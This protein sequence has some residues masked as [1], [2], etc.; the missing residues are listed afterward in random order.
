M[1]KSNVCPYSTIGT[2]KGFLLQAWNVCLQKCFDEEITFLIDIFTNNGQLRVKEKKNARK[3][4]QKS[5]HE[6]HLKQ[7]IKSRNK[8]LTLLNCHGYQNLDRNWEEGYVNS[9]LKPFLHQTK[10][11][12]FYFVRKF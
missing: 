4:L 3:A 11:W 10:I 2:F 5:Y 6:K 8:T 1:Y 9:I 12:N 7:I